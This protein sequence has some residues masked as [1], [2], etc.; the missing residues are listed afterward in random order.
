MGGP[1]AHNTLRM[2]ISTPTET[3]KSK[4][5]NQSGV[6]AG[7]KGW[8]NCIYRA[9]TLASSSARGSISSL[10]FSSTCH[11]AVLLGFSR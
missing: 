8:R 2:F 11:L 3:H 10:S 1:G 5:L 4:G 9:S 6:R 7:G